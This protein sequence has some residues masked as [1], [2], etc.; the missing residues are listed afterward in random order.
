[1]NIERSMLNYEYWMPFLNSE[2]D[3][4][5]SAFPPHARPRFVLASAPRLSIFRF[6]QSPC[7]LDSQGLAI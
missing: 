7:S 1:V 6:L 3:V 5:C 2:L 4:G